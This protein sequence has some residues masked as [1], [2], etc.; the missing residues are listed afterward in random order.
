MLYFG[1]NFASI[2]FYILQDAFKISLYFGFL[3]AHQLTLETLHCILIATLNFSSENMR[4]WSHI[5]KFIQHRP[6]IDRKREKILRQ[7]SVCLESQ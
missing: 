7:S 5:C 1:G 4:P 3:I 2:T 6:H